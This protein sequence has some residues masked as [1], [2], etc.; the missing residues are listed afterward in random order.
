MTIV[1]P[2]EVASTPLDPFGGGLCWGAG[3]LTYGLPE[4]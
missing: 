3:L 4:A 2:V 1:P